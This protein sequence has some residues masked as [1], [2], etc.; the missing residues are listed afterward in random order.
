M[1][2]HAAMAAL[3]VVAG[4]A[5]VGTPADSRRAIPAY[6][7]FSGQLIQLSADQNN[8]GVIDQWTYLSGNRPLRGEA[9]TDG[10]GRIDRWEYFDGNAQLTRVGTSSRNDGVEDTW[11]YTAVNGERR[12]ARSNS[13]DRHVDR[14]ELYRGDAL[15][16]VEEDTNGDGRVDKW[17]RYDN[18][19]L[20]EVG[21]DLAFAGTPP[22]RRVRYDEQGRFVAVEDDP[23]GDGNFVVLTGSAAEAAKAGVKR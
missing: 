10:D 5:C 6:D 3:M 11:T 20:R 17:E 13:R 9:D 23:D 15:V 8:D 2:R 12:V 18:A 1:P 22:T 21:F 16:G 19:V 7:A 14:R 4:A